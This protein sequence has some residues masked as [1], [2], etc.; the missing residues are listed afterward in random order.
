MII[1]GELGCLGT[2][3]MCENIKVDKCKQMRSIWQN[4]KLEHWL[5]HRNVKDEVLGSTLGSNKQ[6]VFFH[7]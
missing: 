1:K 7:V 2:K 4:D 3:Q 5:M 6:K